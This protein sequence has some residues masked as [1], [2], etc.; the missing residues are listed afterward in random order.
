M[1]FYEKVKAL[2]EKEGFVISNLGNVLP[3]NNI[4][5]GSISKWKSGTKP[6]AKNIK[7]IAD[8]FGVPV[9]Y[10][11]DDEKELTADKNRDIKTALFGEG[12]TV[13]DEMWNELMTFVDYLKNKYNID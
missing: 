8:Y 6:R 3:D 10:L 12:V 5:K 2:C 13:T 4:T 9:D 7:A 1:S 11:T